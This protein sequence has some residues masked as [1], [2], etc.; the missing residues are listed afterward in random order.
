MT[1]ALAT[2]GMKNARLRREAMLRYVCDP[3]GL[4]IEELAQHPM[5]K[6]AIS[7]RTLER[8]ASADR[9]VD[10]RQ[11]FIADWAAKARE[12]LGNRMV[13]ERIKEMD[14]LSEIVEVGVSKIRG[15][16]VAP[17]S[18]EGV[19][20]AV[21]D[22]LKYKDELRQ[23]IG[24]D[25]IDKTV[26]GAKGLPAELPPDLPEIDA[27]AAARAALIAKREKR[28]AGLLP[29]SASSQPDV[30]SPDVVQP[31]DDGVVSHAMVP[32]AVAAEPEGA[33]DARTLEEAAE[34]MEDL[35]VRPGDDQEG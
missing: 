24:D 15:D 18:L 2:G 27:A 11:K 33:A 28:R 7:Q 20:K 34:G 25:I 5:F 22:G 13:Q 12:R 1:K 17:K 35:R 9:W 23:A 31:G 4:T 8:W 14:V 6:G 30:S 19:I 16:L 29:A 10:E 32:H 26:E 3:N 21:I